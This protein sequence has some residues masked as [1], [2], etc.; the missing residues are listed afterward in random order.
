[1]LYNTNPLYETPDGGRFAEA[2]AKIPFV[3]SF[4]STLDETAA[5]ADLVLP[6][7]TFLESWGD[8]YIEGCGYAGVSLRRPVVAPVHDTRAAGDVLLELASRLGKPLSDALP[9]RDYK[10]LIQHRLSA[11]DVSW[12]KLRANGSW[13]EMVYRHAQPGSAEWDN[14]VGRDRLNAP[15]DGRFD[16]FSRELFAALEAPED[17]DCL[18]RF[19]RP[20]LM[21][22]LDA[23]SYPF[24]LI[25]QS[26]ITHSRAWQGIVPTLQECYGL[27][28]NYKWSS[29]VEIHPRAARRL[30]VTNH[31]WVWV[32]SSVG[33]VKA[34]VCLYEG[35]WPNVVFMPPGQGHRTLMGW[36]RGLP[37][38]APVG[39]NPANVLATA[40][41]PLSGQTISGPTRVKI[42]KA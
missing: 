7:S 16:F 6:T 30:G 2:L 5:R 8:D 4:A 23:D 13:S 32:E 42:H 40:T 35:L 10:S 27:P 14:V 20:A 31:D 21:T 41:E 34:P 29:W 3:V 26:L 36:G 9:W 18:P 11:I 37:L 33:R 17:R 24:L 38:R 22:D 15:K 25:N 39:T 1:L 12:D 19:E 28:A